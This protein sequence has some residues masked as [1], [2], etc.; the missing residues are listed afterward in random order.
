MF[1]LPPRTC[2]VNFP[3]AMRSSA[4]RNWTHSPRRAAPS[5]VPCV[6]RA[7]VPISRDDVS[8]ESASCQE[9]PGDV[10]GAVVRTIIDHDHLEIAGLSLD[11]RQRLLDPL[12]RIERGHDDADV[13]RRARAIHGE[14]PWANPADA[15]RAGVPT[16]EPYEVSARWPLRRTG[17][18]VKGRQDLE[19]SGA[20]RSRSERDAT[21]SG[22]GMASSGSSQAMV[23]SSLGSWAR[24]IR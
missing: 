5:D 14:S 6:G 16:G 19:R 10:P 13:H 23:T 22:Q 8:G 21:G 17:S 1:A 20:I 24:S 2:T 9:S 3:A 15:A 11:A 7:A 18:V 4:S 12:L